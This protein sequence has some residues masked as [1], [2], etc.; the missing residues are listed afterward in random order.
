MQI[1]ERLEKERVMLYLRRDSCWIIYVG[2]LF[3][4]YKYCMFFV[5]FII[6]TMTLLTINSCFVIL[7]VITDRVLRRFRP[8][9]GV[10]LGCAYT[11]LA[12]L[13]ELVLACWYY[14]SSIRDLEFSRTQ[15]QWA[16]Q[17]PVCFNTI[18]ALA[19]V[20][21]H[22]TVQ[23]RQAFTSHKQ[24]TKQPKVDPQANVDR[25][26]M[27]TKVVHIRIYQLAFNMLVSL[28]VGCLPYLCINDLLFGVDDRLHFCMIS[29]QFLLHCH[30]PINRQMVKT[31]L[32]KQYSSFDK[33]LIIF[34]KK[35]MSSV[36]YWQVCCNLYNNDIN[37]IFRCTVPLSN[38]TC[39]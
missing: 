13:Q 23:H 11:S 29:L 27:A 28:L 1:A 14:L 26:D 16:S 17:Q 6:K 32:G 15:W 20:S 24:I 31:E 33:L 12:A 10:G 18:W 37:F 9:M 22:S 21:W 3:N 8:G 25:Y 2:L 39:R 38:L 4:L 19:G 5:H 30:Q 35:N 34:L 36:I 7:S